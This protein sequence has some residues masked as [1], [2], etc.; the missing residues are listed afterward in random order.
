M[1]V[2]AMLDLVVSCY[3]LLEKAPG[4]VWIAGTLNSLTHVLGTAERKVGSLKAPALAKATSSPPPHC[5]LSVQVWAGG[6]LVL[7]PSGMWRCPTSLILSTTTLM[8]AWS[9]P[10]R[11]QSAQHMR[12][13]HHSTRRMPNPMLTIATVWVRASEAGTGLPVRSGSR[14]PRLYTREHA[15]PLGRICEF[16]TWKL[17]GPRLIF[18]ES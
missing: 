5:L 13:D 15:G 8:V 16:F 4:K 10:L 3:P 11:G 7:L 6:F 18:L 1:N 17:L 9:S 12:R 14:L 2:V